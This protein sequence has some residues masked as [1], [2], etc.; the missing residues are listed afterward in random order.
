VA[1]FPQLMAGPIM[2]A[3]ELLPQLVRP[4][5]FVRLPFSA[6]FA[7]SASLAKKVLFADVR[8]TFPRPG[9]RRHLRLSPVSAV[10]AL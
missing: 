6:G 8:G 9:L 5:A 10:L 7:R 2:R 1:F 3:G 4:P